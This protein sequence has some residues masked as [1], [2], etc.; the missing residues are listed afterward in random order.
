[1]NTRALGLAFPFVVGAAHRTLVCYDMVGYFF[2]T[3]FAQC[4]LACEDDWWLVF[5]TNGTFHGV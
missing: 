4:V 2:V 1:M 3:I 5:V